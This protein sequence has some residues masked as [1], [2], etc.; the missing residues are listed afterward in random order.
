M[1]TKYGITAQG[2]DQS[3]IEAEEKPF[4]KGR[5]YSEAYPLKGMSLK[6]Y[7]GLLHSGMFW[8]WYPEATGNY[9][10]DTK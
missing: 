10:E 9:E 3:K 8:E 6:Q 2:I 4:N 5:Y 7:E 1:K